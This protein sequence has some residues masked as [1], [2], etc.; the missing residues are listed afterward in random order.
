[1]SDLARGLAVCPL[2]GRC[3]GCN[4]LHLDEADYV[5]AKEESVRAAFAERGLAPP[6]APLRR[7]PLAS[8]RRAT[9]TAL[10]G[11]TGVVVGYQAAR[12]HEVVDVDR[13]PALAPPLA[14]ALPAIRALATAA[15]GSAG[16][17]RL[18][19]TA[20][21]NGIDVAITT[22][23]APKPR[24]RRKPKPARRPPPAPITDDPGIIR[25]TLDGDIGFVRE[26]PTMRFDGVTI[27][28][29]AAAF[30]QASAEGEAHLVSLVTEAAAGAE[31]L[32]DAFCGL[33]TFAVPLTR[34][35]KVRAVEADGTALAALTEGI[36]HAAGRRPLTTERRNLFHHPLSTA[37]LAAF[38]TVV[39]DPPRAGAEAFARALATAP[40]P[41]VI[42]VS[43]APS[44]LARD[45]EILISGGYEIIAASPVDQFVGS[46]HIECVAVLRKT[47]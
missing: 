29:P 3:G 42:A 47:P 16:R 21:A 8:R 33:G 34:F 32:L 11:K 1:M 17:A 43:C 38:D 15:A 36:S 2:Y 28:F 35:A 24:G 12:S 41:T 23:P 26:P 44:T 20:C 46:D 45:A 13:C 25:L 39:F 31:N 9:F 18:T 6:L 7:A 10:A 22:P 4:R 19:A 30:I 27:P 40:V 14:A 37:E 5:A